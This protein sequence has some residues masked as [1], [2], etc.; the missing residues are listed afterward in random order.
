VCLCAVVALVFLQMQELRKVD[1]Y[2]YTCL[3]IYKDK[4]VLFSPILQGCI[5]IKLLECDILGSPDRVL[6]CTGI[7]E[8]DVLSLE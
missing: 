1:K 7:L 3:Q 4:P 5:R 2:L 6:D 8:C